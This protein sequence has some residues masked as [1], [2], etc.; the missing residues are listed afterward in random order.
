MGN[1]GTGFMPAPC[2]VIVMFRPYGAIRVADG[3][4]GRNLQ[5]TNQVYKTVP[6]IL[7]AFGVFLLTAIILHTKGL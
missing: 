3:H 4:R 5:I 6:T 7:Y 2:N 1:A